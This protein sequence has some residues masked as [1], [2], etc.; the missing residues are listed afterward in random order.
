MPLFFILFNTFAAKILI[1]SCVHHSRYSIHQKHMHFIIV[2][3]ALTNT[4][5]NLFLHIL[6]LYFSYKYDHVRNGCIYRGERIYV[7]V[8]IKHLHSNGL[9]SAIL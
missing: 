8:H 2:Q 6:R 4:G 3:L 7:R 5:V 9:L 1:T